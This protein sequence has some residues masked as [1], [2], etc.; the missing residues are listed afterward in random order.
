MGPNLYHQT[1]LHSLLSLTSYCNWPRTPGPAPSPQ[2]S[3]MESLM[4]MQSFSE[5]KMHQQTTAGY[6]QTTPPFDLPFVW[7]RPA[8]SQPAD[9]TASWSAV[10]DPTFWVYKTRRAEELLLSLSKILCN[11]TSIP[12]PSSLKGTPLSFLASHCH[13]SWAETSISL[14]SDQDFHEAYVCVSYTVLG[15]EQRTWGVCVT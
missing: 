6:Q 13:L 14:S 5:G 4:F 10:P 11:C 2:K 9:I 7:R 3:S 1:N 15:A 12:T 8:R